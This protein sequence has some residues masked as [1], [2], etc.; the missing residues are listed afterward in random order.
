M[1]S[2]KVGEE[3]YIVFRGSAAGG[4]RKCGWTNYTE[5]PFP[6][7]ELAALEYQHPFCN[8]TAK[9][10]AADFVTSDTGTGF[11][12]IAPGHGQDDYNL[13][14]ANGLPIYSPVDDDGNLPTPTICPP[15]SK[16]PPR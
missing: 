8:R 2:V 4:C 3:N 14:R 11:V 10:F 1:S 13:G 9:L 15:N 5:T 16:C 12:H 6:I 7:E